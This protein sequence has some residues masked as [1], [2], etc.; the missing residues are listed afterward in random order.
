MD[1]VVV[2]PTMHAFLIEVKDYRTIGTGKP[3]DLPGAVAKKVL[4]TLAGLVA[5]RLN[6]SDAVEKNLA[7]QFCRST[8]LSV[9][10]H[11]EQPSRHMPVVNI[12]D[13]EMKLRQVLK[14][15]DRRVAVTQMSSATPWSVSHT[16]L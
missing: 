14:S 4:D 10:L 13:V 9:V 11:C 15:V 2:S 8:K 7:D 3:S 1:L 6:A 16:V 5:A 12:A